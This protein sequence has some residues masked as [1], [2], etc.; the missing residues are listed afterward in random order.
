MQVKMRKRVEQGFENGDIK[1]LDPA[2]FQQQGWVATENNR[3]YL[4]DGALKILE[5]VRLGKGSVCRK[6]LLP[7]S[8]ICRTAIS[9]PRTIMSLKF[10]MSALST[11]ISN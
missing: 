5:Q 4:T 7:F 1:A 8:N 2:A 10:L 6:F 3:L 11:H 9:F